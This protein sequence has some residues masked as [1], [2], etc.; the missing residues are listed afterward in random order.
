MSYRERQEQIREQIREASDLR[1][2][3]AELGIEVNSSGLAKCV[4]HNDHD[5]SMSVS[6]SYGGTCFGCHKTFDVFTLVQQV[7]GLPFVDALKFLAARAGI[8]IGEE[9]QDDEE[10]QAELRRMSERKRV[11]DILHDAAGFFHKSLPTRYRKQVRETYGLDDQ[12][13]DRLLIGWADGEALRM[14]LCDG[15]GYSEQEILSSGLFLKFDNPVSFF[16][17]RITIPYLSHGRAVYMIGRQTR[18]TEDVPHEQAKYKKLLTH[19]DKH[20][21]V[22]QTVENSWLFGEDSIRRD[23]ALITEGVFDCAAL[24]MLGYSAISPVTVQARKKDTPRLV[25]MTRRIPRVTII[26]DNEDNQS[27]AKGAIAMGDA[28]HKA[29]RQVYIATIPRPEGVTKIDVCDLVSSIKRRGREQGSNEDELNAAARDAV[30]RIIEDAKPYIEFLYSRIDKSKAPG[31]LN[32]ELRRIF[33]LIGACPPIERDAYAQKIARHFDLSR[34]TVRAS[35]AEFVSP[36]ERRDLQDDQAEQEQ[37]AP[38][39]D[40]EDRVRGR[41]FEDVDRYYIQGRLADETISSFTIIGREVVKTETGE[42]WINASVRIRGLAKDIEHTFP[43]KAWSSRRDFVKE[44]LT[45]HPA[46]QFMGSDD[47]V[48]GIL[49]RVAAET[50]PTR[51]G[52]NAI[53]LVRTDDGLRWL[54]PNGVITPRGIEDSD[55]AEIKFIRN[56]APIQRRL[57]YSPTDQETLRKVCAKVLPRLLS[58]NEPRITTPILGFTIAS[59]LKP[60]FFD[61]LGHF[62]IL[63]VHGTQGSGKTSI[64]RDVFWRL[65]GV[66]SDPF[67]CTDTE[68]AK[69]KNLSA[70][71]SVFCFYDELKNDMGRNRMLGWLRMLRRA[72]NGEFE[73]RGRADQ[74]VL[75]YKLQAPIVIAGETRPDG[76][77]AL[78]ERLISVNPDKNAINDPSF[79]RAFNEV[80]ESRLDQISAGLVMHLLQVDFADTMTKARAVTQELLAQTG[81]TV[82]LRCLDSLIVVLAGLILFEGFADSIS[83]ELPEIDYVSAFGAIVDEL[84]EGGS[85]VKDSFDS[86]V[87]YCSILAHL[88]TI[89]DGKHYTILEDGTI[90]MHV[91]SCFKV[92]AEERSRAGGEAEIAPRALLRIA[93][94]KLDAGNS[95]VRAFESKLVGPSRVNCVILDPEAIPK[96]LDVAPFPAGRSS[97]SGFGASWGQGLEN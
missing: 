33:E 26:N 81:K 40:D 39:F 20:P 92:Y 37:S 73:T 89:R 4:F 2:V 63:L 83:V 57:E 70:A 50:L 45:I 69:A 56:G 44:V 23:H 9:D 82:P 36:E 90:A 96:T 16:D 71:T 55:Q 34:A 72:Y 76:D 95:Y 30:D 97:M 13:I 3:A 52:S 28:L 54:T 53:G 61:Q 14:F 32:T 75:E 11:Q 27:G 29:G 77:P 60:L 8:E 84:L 48:Q 25:A 24:I 74:S 49:Q 88:G 6:R 94:E 78:T 41:V 87:E 12:T 15:L 91:A 85:D 43:P 47:N 10:F 93:K 80:S 64:V 1:E 17:A 7:K 59:M 62:P 46:C 22:S 5:P 31:E 66:R 38:R 19:S 65:V 79:K 21:Y 67:S 86:F 35:I 68:F 18:D 58:L 51:Q 42:Q